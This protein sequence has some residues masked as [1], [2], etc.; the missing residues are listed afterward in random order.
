M[1]GVPAISKVDGSLQKAAWMHGELTEGPLATRKV[2]GSR[3]KI[4]R[5]HGI[6]T[7]VDEHLPTTQ[8]VIGS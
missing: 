7:K 6:L 4:S 5:L 3:R 1:E 2:D 8:K